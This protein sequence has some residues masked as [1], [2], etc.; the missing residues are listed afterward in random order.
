[1]PRKTPAQ[2]AEAAVAAVIKQRDRAQAEVDRLNAVLRKL[3]VTIGVPQERVDLSA[4]PPAGGWPKEVEDLMAQGR[5][6]FPGSDAPP[7]ADPAP[8][9]VEIA[10][11]DNMGAG[12]WA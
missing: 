6:P 11:H 4:A 9:G 12:R 2:R 7:P 3:G 10:P 8:S 5:P 1:M